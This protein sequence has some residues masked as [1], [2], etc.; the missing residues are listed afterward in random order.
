MQQ[1][2]D[3][4]L[5]QA[6]FWS[7]TM[8]FDR[9]ATTLELAVRFGKTL[10]VEEADS[11]EPLLYTLL[12]CDTKGQ[13]SNIKIGDRLVDLNR[14]FRLVLVTRNAKPQLPSGAM[15]LLTVAN[16]TVTRYTFGCV[17]QA[18]LLCNSSQH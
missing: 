18:T 16:F 6:P 5:A 12:T 2:V 8:H 14:D 9:F 10:I 13:S 7:M 4:M 15:A 3:R 11:I 1:M 17:Q